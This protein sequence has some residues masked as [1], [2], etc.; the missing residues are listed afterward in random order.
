M[1]TWSLE[2]RRTLRKQFK[3]WIIDGSIADQSMPSCHLSPILEKHAADNTRWVSAHDRASV[4]S[5]T[6]NR[7]QEIWEENCYMVH[8]NRVRVAIDHVRKI[9]SVDRE[10]VRREDRAQ[11]HQ[12]A[13]DNDLKLKCLKLVFK[14]SLYFSLTF[15]IFQL[16]VYTN[17]HDLQ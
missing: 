16:S 12:D 17:L 13:R 2:D 1:F 6:S 10:V 14:S 15:M 11:D 7:S 3:I 5:C 9:V 4:I 8:Q